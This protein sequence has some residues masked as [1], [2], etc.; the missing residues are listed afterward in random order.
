[1]VKKKSFKIALLVVLI[2]FLS[3]ILYWFSRPKEVKLY[4]GIHEGSS[5]GVPQGQDN[6]VLDDIIDRFEK[7]HP[8]VDVVYESGIRQS[9]YSDWLAEKMAKGEEPDLFMVPD[10]DFNLLASLGSLKDLKPFVSKNFD[11]DRFYKVS[12][13]AG[14]YHGDQ[15]ALP[16]E[17]NPIMMCINKDL[18]EKSGFSIPESDWSVTDFYKMAKAVTKDVDGDGQLD[19]FGLVDYE[20]QNAMAAYGNP[21][22]NANGDQVH[23]N[24]TAT[25]NAMTLMMNLTALS[26][27][28]EVSAQ[29]F[30]QGKVV[31]RPMTL[32]E[33]RTYKPYP[34]HIAKY[35]TFE[36]TCVPMPSAR[37]ES[38]ATQV[39]TS[40]FAISD[41]TKKAALAWEL[42]RLLTYDNDS[43]QALVK[44]SQGASV[45]KTVMTSQETQQLLQEDTFGS[46]SLT[47]PMLDHTLRDGFNLPKFK[48]FNAV[49]EETDYL[50]NQSLKNGTIET[51]LAMIE[52]KLA[53]SLR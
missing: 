21:I 43:Q 13:Q 26:G 45:L 41:R 27:N 30:D 1:M 16:F 10:K 33:Y 34:Y 44:Q 14:N 49:Y 37:A 3:A 19:Q 51:D 9:D 42:L 40:L 2:S 28:Y 38:Q 5:W 12:Y 15:Y 8:G 52:K 23:L 31:F 22:F 25:K 39:E 48:Q 6:R 17:S 53:Q 50:I 35:T 32:A 29:D 4:L 24:T 11:D 47:A 18:L 20:W 36:W 7:D 46:D